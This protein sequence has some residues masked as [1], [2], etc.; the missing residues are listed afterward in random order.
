M[1]PTY[2]PLEFLVYVAMCVC[3]EGY[4]TSLSLIC[5]A[6]GG[7]RSLSFSYVIFLLH[8]AIN[9]KHLLNL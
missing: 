8:A 4:A 1:T 9:W 2:V 7:I 6:G 5:A 3:V